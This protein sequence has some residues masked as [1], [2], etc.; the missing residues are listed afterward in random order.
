MLLDGSLA[1]P[2]ATEEVET[3][4]CRVEELETE[5]QKSRHDNILFQKRLEI[6]EKIVEAAFG[7]EVLRSTTL[8]I[9]FYSTKMNICFSTNSY[10][11]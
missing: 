9:C 8:S 5:L 4:T 2:Q 7:Q 11:F 1:S 3:L 6:M 10:G